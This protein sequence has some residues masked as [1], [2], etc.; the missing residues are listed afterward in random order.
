MVWNYY[1]ASGSEQCKGWPAWVLPR[2]PL[3]DCLPPWLLGGCPLKAHSWALSQTSFSVEAAVT[4][5]FT[6]LWNQLL[7]KTRWYTCGLNSGPP[8]PVILL[9]SP[10]SYCLLHNRPINRERSYWERKG[11]FIRK[12]SRWKRWG[13]SAPKNHLPRFRIQASFIL[14]RE[15]I[16]SWFQPDSRGVVLISSFPQSFTGGPGQDGPCELNKGI[17]A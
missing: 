5:K 9:P 16:K 4:P 3:E 6:P 13:T 2:F 17:L 11:H 14:K 7:S 10:S 12:A 1:T 8:W 15:G